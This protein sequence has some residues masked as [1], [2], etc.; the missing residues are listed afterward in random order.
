MVA[1]LC[2]S[3]LIRA[4][5][6]GNGA[7]EFV[8]RFRLHKPPTAGVSTVVQP[9]VAA[10]AHDVQSGRGIAG[11]G[12]P[13][14]VSEHHL[15]VVIA[16]RSDR[17]ER[18]TYRRGHEPQFNAAMWQSNPA[19]RAI[20]WLRSCGSARADTL[21]SNDARA[22]IPEG[23]H[24]RVRRVT[25]QLET[26]LERT[27]TASYFSA[28]RLADGTNTGAAGIEGPGRLPCVYLCDQ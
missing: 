9:A 12:D 28:F 23:V 20:A 21:A 17:R 14:P 19:E 25:R 22:V 26:G 15:G 16:E 18:R 2:A 11:R 1:N 27:Q 4:L 24:R 6:T 8:C 13:H 10:R 3:S 7:P 5:A